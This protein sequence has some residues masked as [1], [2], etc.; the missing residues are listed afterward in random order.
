MAA[1]RNLVDAFHKDDLPTIKPLIPDLLNQLF[2]LMNEASSSATHCCSKS[3]SSAI[4]GRHFTL[5]TC[6][7][8]VSFSSS[9]VHVLKDVI[10][11]RIFK[12]NAI[13]Q[14]ES[15]DVVFALETIVENFGGEM[16]PFAVG[17]CQHLT[18]AF[19]RLQASHR[20][21]AVIK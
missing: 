5:A 13:M 8:S 21:T 17:L 9:L 11:I 1:L 16:A 4:V 14:V 12:R 20:C 15:E 10:K 3:L 18:Q 2:A 19:W 7:I 6:P